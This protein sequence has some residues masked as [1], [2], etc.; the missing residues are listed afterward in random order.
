MPGRT[1]TLV[2]HRR[3]ESPENTNARQGR[4]LV[5]MSIGIDRGMGRE[6]AR[7]TIQS[8]RQ[9]MLDV[10]EVFQADR[11]TQQALFDAGGRFLLIA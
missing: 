1:P 10:V 7:Q 4:A 8:A 6:S 3:A 11:D 2:D 5:S 9:I